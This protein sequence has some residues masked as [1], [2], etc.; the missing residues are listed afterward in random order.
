M[1]K[2][3]IFVIVIVSIVIWS[4]VS[5]E[6]VKPSDE[7]NWQKM[8]TLLSVGTLLVLGVTISLFQSLPF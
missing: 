1:S 3:A 8:I 2:D 4:A 6:A 5:H 7:I